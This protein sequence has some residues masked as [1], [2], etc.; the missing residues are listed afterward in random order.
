MKL[1]TPL[2]IVNFKTYK[3]ATDERAVRLAR[4]CYSVAKKTKTNIAVAVQNTD[5]YQ[6]S[7][8]VKIPILSEH[9]DPITYGAH[10]GHILPEAVKK[11]GAAGVLINHSEDRLKL[12]EIK[13]TIERAKESKLKTVVCAATTKMATEITRFNPDF[14]AI[15]PPELIGGDISVSKARPSL[16]TNTIKAVH[17]IRKIPILCGAGIKT[18]EDV[19]KAYQLGVKGILVASGIIKAKNPEKILK[20]FA[21]V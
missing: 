14:I 17:K 3:E 5:I 1:K 20:E 2:I 13:K 6:I 21:S 11:G 18:K 16:I 12:E 15:E 19:E 7:K 8:A 9:I 4:I 10:T